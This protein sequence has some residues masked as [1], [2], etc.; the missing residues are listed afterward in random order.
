MNFKPLLLPQLPALR[1][2]ILFYGIAFLIMVGV[3]LQ[4]FVKVSDLTRDAVVVAKGMFYFGLISNLGILLWC[5]TAAIC[6]FTVV[7]LNVSKITANRD[8]LL[9]G[10]LLTTFLLLDDFMLLHEEAI[11]KLLG[12][13]EKYVVV[14]YPLLM[15]LYLAYFLNKILDTSY[16]VLLSALGFLALSVLTDAVAPSKINELE[17]LFED[18]FKLMG[19]AGWFYYFTSTSLKVLQSSVEK[20]FSPVEEAH[21]ALEAVA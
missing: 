5:A 12:I 9:Y 13:G 10:G 20:R 16:L 19:I 18:G 21:K 17:V 6:L 2:A 1:K 14:V 7:Y 15:V 8:F 4:P 3:Y 11:P